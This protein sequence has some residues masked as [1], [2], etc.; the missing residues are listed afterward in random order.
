MQFENLLENL[1][2][3]ITST[4]G[5]A[6]LL[7]AL[8]ITIVVQFIK[9]T[10]INKLKIDLQKKFDPTFLLPFIFG[11]IAAVIDTVIIKRTPFLGFASVYE[12][13]VQGI[14][15]GATSAAIYKAFA[16]L[17]K[18][19]I[20]TLCRDGV[21]SILYNEILIVSDIKQK[22]LDKDISLTEFLVKLKEAVSG[23]KAIYSKDIDLPDDSDNKNTEESYI[24]ENAETA[25]KTRTEQQKIQC[26]K[27]V[28]SG[29]ISSDNLEQVATTLNKALANTTPITTVNRV[30]F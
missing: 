4:D 18:N 2:N 17:D 6:F 28:I 3:L 1:F 23:I 16:A 24:E 7:Q 19:N 11:C 13:A 10:F 25:A 29:L 27:T 9:T 8:L 21:F 26:L 5:G 14:S 22:L 12:I 30:I 15:I 20:K